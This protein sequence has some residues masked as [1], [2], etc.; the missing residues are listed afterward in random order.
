MKRIR[1][2]YTHIGTHLIIIYKNNFEAEHKLHERTS[3]FLDGF[4]LSYSMNCSGGKVNGNM[5]WAYPTNVIKTLFLNL[6]SV[7]L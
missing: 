6:D 7:L 4:L 5:V 2:F 1:V 3:L